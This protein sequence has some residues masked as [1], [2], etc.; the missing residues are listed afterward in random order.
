MSTPEQRKSARGN[1]KK[2]DLSPDSKVK[3]PHDLTLEKRLIGAVLKT[4]DNFD[5]IASLCDAVFLNSTHSAIWAAAKERVNRG[6]RASPDLI[7]AT[8]K[9][10]DG[11]NERIRNI[12]EEACGL[13]AERSM[14]S[15]YAKTL[16]DLAE[17]RT[18]NAHSADYLQQSLERNRRGIL[19]D[20]RAAIDAA[21][22]L[23]ETDAA[24]G[25]RNNVLGTFRAYDSI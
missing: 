17:L 4:N 9:T 3:L 20:M 8:F 13:A 16:T 15:E 10:P 24:A 21:A 11:D 25:G 18:C 6:Q 19:D 2:P 14:L 7:A 5:E 12:C 22:D 1:G 23:K